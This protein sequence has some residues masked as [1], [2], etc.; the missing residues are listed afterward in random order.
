MDLAKWIWLN[1]SGGMD[2]AEGEARMVVNADM[3]IFPAIA[4]NRSATR[5][6]DWRARHAVVRAFKPP[7]FLDVEM[8]QVARGFAF[9]AAHLF[10]RVK[11]AQA[12]VTGQ[13]DA[14]PG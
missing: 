5:G 11:I 6:L 3:H 4:A 13:R 7:E 9:I 14:A 2:L 12:R 10:G 1:G 8:D